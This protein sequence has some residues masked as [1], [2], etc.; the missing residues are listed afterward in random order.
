MKNPNGFLGS[1]KQNILSHMFSHI[2]LSKT[3]IIHKAEGSS[4]PNFHQQDSTSSNHNQ[5]L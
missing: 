3:F 5:I 2:K 1:M 4:N